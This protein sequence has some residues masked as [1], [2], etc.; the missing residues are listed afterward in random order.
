LNGYFFGDFAAFERKGIT[1][2]AEAYYRVKLSLWNIKH[3][4]DSLEANLLIV[5]VPASIQVTDRTELDYYP[6]NV[7]LSDTT[8]FDL[9][10]PQR[11][12]REIADSLAIRFLDLRVS[13]SARGTSTFYQR[14]NMHWTIDGHDVVARASS[15]FIEH[16]GFLNSL[17][18]EKKSTMILGRTQK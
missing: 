14:K 15:D 12:T 7:N 5:M 18:G 13:L 2:T 9:E 17:K 1:A 3:V 6:N 11:K 16:E 10:M 4:A 8:Q